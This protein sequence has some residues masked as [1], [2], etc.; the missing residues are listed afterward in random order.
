MR[1]PSLLRKFADDEGGAALVLV[2]VTLPVLVGFSLLA[3]D[4]SRVNNLHNDLQKAA[5]AFALAA[6]A[7]LDGQA[8]AED[9]AERALLNLVQNSSKF[10]DDGT[11]LLT[12]D[13]DITWR[14]LEEL[15]ATDD[16][17]IVD[18]PYLSEDQTESRF[19][20][21]T[22]TP[23]GFSSIFPASFLGGADTFSV[24]AVAV[25]GFAGVVTCD[26]TP[27]FICNPFPEDDLGDIVTNN[28]FY[29][30][31][32]MLIPGDELGPGNFGFLRPESAHGYGE[33]ELASDL[34][35]TH[36]PECVNTLGIFTQ[37]GTLTTA[38]TNGINTRFDMGY[39]Q[40]AN[41]FSSTDE[42]VAPAPNVRKGYTYV[43]HGRQPIDP[44]D[45]EPGED[46]ALFMGFPRD[47]AHLTGGTEL[48]ADGLWDYEAYIAVNNIDVSIAD[49]SY[50]SGFV[51]D[52]GNLYSNEN[53]PSR[54]D[55]YMYEI[56]T[57]QVGTL[58]DG[59]ETGT[60]ACHSSVAGPERR[61]IYAAVVNCDQ[62]EDE[63][64]GQSGTAQAIG[65]ASFF[66][67][68]PSNGTD[69][70]AEIVD[71]DGIEGRGTMID[72]ARDNVQLYR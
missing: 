12:R 42:T 61:L 23:T 47:D 21:V 5:D 14:F 45:M 13:G 38:A 60:P 27:L 33:Q 41:G 50:P 9:R 3:I 16:L 26:M 58:S 19:I 37:T 66:L 6:A 43:Q 22:V 10:S 18:D 34:A 62:Y 20:E 24:G 69:V 71:I 15:P 29:R 30:S 39:S 65:Y 64:R 56:E 72:F 46:P 70:Y 51:D 35:R 36:V 2:T 67:T 57:A 53:P 49:A 44:C 68:E 54:F 59:Q 55:L 40:G 11:H 4:M 25:G 48:I 63:L 7:E 17:P 32:I 8:D 52:D 31:G 28:S 1:A